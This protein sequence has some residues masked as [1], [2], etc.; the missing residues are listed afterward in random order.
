MKLHIC[1][2]NNLTNILRIYISK[3]NVLK[4]KYYHEVFQL[5][6]YT[7]LKNFN[8]LFINMSSEKNHNQNCT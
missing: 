6:F 4:E 2:L 7:L 8:I 1:T 5:K 3:D